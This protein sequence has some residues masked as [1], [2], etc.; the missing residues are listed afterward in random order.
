MASTKVKILLKGIGS[1]PV[2]TSDET[3]QI[4]L[5]SADEPSGVV[6]SSIQ[7]NDE[8]KEA[9]LEY[10]LRAEQGVD[11]NG[12]VVSEDATSLFDI[13]TGDDNQAYLVVDGDLKKSNI[14]T[15]QLE[16][17]ANDSAHPKEPSTSV[18]RTVVVQ[19]EK[20]EDVPMELNLVALP[21][22][23]TIPHDLAVGSFVYRAV[24]LPNNNNVTFTIE[25]EH[26]FKVFSDGSIITKKELV[27]EP[28]SIP[29]QVMATDGLIKKSSES[30]L[31]LHKK[32]RA[33]FTE[34]SYEA[35]LPR[36]SPVGSV[37]ALVSAV[38]EKGEAV[39]NFIVKGGH[40]KMFTVDEQGAVKTEAVL[41]DGS[42]F[43]FLVA[44]ATDPSINAPV[45]VK[46][47]EVRPASISLV[48]NQIFAT[49]F[50]NLPIN[51]FVGRVEVKDGE[52]VKF[53]LSSEEKGMNDLFAIEEDGTIRSTNWL[54]GE[55]EQPFPYSLHF[56]RRRR[57]AQVCGPRQ[58]H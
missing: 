56:P 49:V 18:R 40:A 47:E 2:T 17:T 45:H 50:D 57:N 5:I 43:D 30:T 20:D 31:V 29:I 54:G 3:E 11:E 21:K 26:I 35:S 9:K 58:Q 1:F 23:I 33:H 37:I 55:F 39:K 7:F 53:T 38:N 48:D 52:K 16:I 25:P 36:G 28:Q 51:S 41:T 24:V 44:L 32:M 15:V 27:E 4:E 14:S 34:D 10:V 8:D 13:K 42:E 19:R 6:I 12:N 46:V 22:N